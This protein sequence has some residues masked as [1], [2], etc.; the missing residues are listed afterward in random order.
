MKIYEL[1]LIITG[2]LIIVTILVLLSIY[3]LVT[4]GINLAK[5]RKT[6]ILAEFSK[7]PN[8]NQIVFL[9]DSLTDFYPIDE[10]FKN[11]FI[12]NRG[13]GGD[14]TDDVLNR[15]ATNVYPLEP[16]VVFL[17]IGTNDL[18][19]KKKPDYV[20]NKIKM[21]TANLQEHIPNV[22]VKIISLYPI[23]RKAFFG[24]FIFVGPRKNKHIITINESL[25]IYCEE[26]NLEYIDVHSHLVDQ[27]GN[28]AKPYTVEGLHI[29]Y[30]GYT[31]ITNV[32][33]PYI[34]E[35]NQ[36]LEEN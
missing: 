13:I 10:F 22:Q 19:Y 1:I 18:M 2:S 35:V 33:S 31:V 20:I 32:L 27:K 9:G 36:P 25:K 23:N 17:Q 15:L 7:R 5:K 26:K 28:L 8:K 34:N 24:S 30:V 29:S 12:Y 16:K 4:K 11:I 3:I 6:E 14:T 21:I